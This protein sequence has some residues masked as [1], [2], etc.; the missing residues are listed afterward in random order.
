MGIRRGMKVLMGVGK[1]REYSVL[2]SVYYKEKPEHLKQAIEN[3]QTQTLP[4]NNFVLVCDGPLND[5]LDDVI[6]IKQQE[7]GECRRK[8]ML[9]LWNLQRSATRLIV[10]A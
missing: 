2:M 3:I 8:T 4:T 1:Y 6:A 10:P 7:M 9:R 5:A